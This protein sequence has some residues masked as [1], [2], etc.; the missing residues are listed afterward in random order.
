MKNER[1]FWVIFF[2]AVVIAGL[3]VRFGY[4]PQISMSLSFSAGSEN[5][6]Y[7]YQTFV[8]PILIK[9]TGSSAI[10]GMEIG[11]FVNGNL[12]S[13]YNVTMP[14]GRNATIEFP[15]TPKSPGPL[16][17]TAVADP[18]KVYDLADRSAASSE[19]RVNIYAPEEAN[20]LSLLPSGASESYRYETG[21]IGYVA[22]SYLYNTYGI[23]KFALSD[24]SAVD[25]FLYPLLNVTFNYVSR[26]EYA[27]AEYHNGTAFSLWTQGYLAPS[28]YYVAAEARG[29]NATNSTVSGRSVTLIPFGNRLSMCVWYEGGWTKVL[30]YNG[31]GSCLGFVGSKPNSTASFNSTLQG[32]VND[33]PGS[34]GTYS[35]YGTS[36]EFGRLLVYNTS[37]TYLGVSQTSRGSNKCYGLVESIGNESYCSSYVLTKTGELGNFSL[38]DTKEIVGGYNVSALTL[39]NQSDI[40]AHARSDIG[41]FDYVNVSGNRTVFQSGIQSSCS[42]SGFN[43]T[44]LGFSR[45]NISIAIKNLHD[46]T[47]ALG[48]ISCYDKGSGIPVRISSELGNNATANI[49]AACYDYGKRI[50]SPPL[51]LNLNLLLNYSAKGSAGTASGSAYIV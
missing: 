12:S 8:L 49:T 47:V 1:Y 41:F 22:F 43:C 44:L 5:A 16:N 17:I 2:A 35:S 26:F 29:L 13:T 46:Y 6:S 4:R 11:V 7:P 20:P 36:N 10:K 28:Q 48:S 25:S 14:A 45:G 40:S 27:G 33:I 19:T 3:Y 37:F 18:G 32:M 23:Q 30:A 15:Y 38:I 34:I 9:N 39:T 24:I 21:S 31:N 50:T 42:L 51:S